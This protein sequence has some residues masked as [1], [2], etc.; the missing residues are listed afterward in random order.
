MVFAGVAADQVRRTAAHTIG[1]RRRLDGLRHL[2]MVGEAEVIVAAET[3]QLASV[4]SDRGALGRLHDRAHAI[5]VERPAF[6][7]AL[8]QRL[9]KVR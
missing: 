6:R 2:G 5:A 9:F 8:L 4:H 3:Y 7:Q 1:A